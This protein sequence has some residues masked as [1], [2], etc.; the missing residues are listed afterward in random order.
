MIIMMG[1]F[2]GNEC[3][4]FY[5]KGRGFFARARFYDSK[6]MRAQKILQLIENK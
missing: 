1:L 6:I 4:S 2:M 3:Y 5:I